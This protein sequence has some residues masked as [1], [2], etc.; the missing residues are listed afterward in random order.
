MSKKYEKRAI[1]SFDGECPMQCRHCFTHD[2]E[3]PLEPD[4][5]LRTPEQIA[6][7]LKDQQFDVIYLSRSYENFLDQKKA[8]HLCRILFD[9]YQKDLL[10]ITRSA[11]EEET[12]KKLG[13]LNRD[14]KQN[15]HRLFLACSFCGDDSYRISEDAVR[16]P[17]PKERMKN[18][19]LAHQYGICTILLLRP[20]FPNVIIPVQ[21]CIDLIDKARGIIDGVISSGLIITENILKRL[22]IERN[23]IPLMEDGDSEYL[24]NIA[25][26]KV[27]YVDVEQEL[28]LIEDHCQELGLPFF[29]HSMPA[30]NALAE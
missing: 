3:R 24:E 16:C 2:L 5:G 13:C 6:D 9:R 19:E 25:K 20:L 7:D 23:R 27:C 18:L 22:Q 28:A 8:L 30:L 11:L 26:D 12:V 21:E 14:M 15:G 17:N 1:V 4:G 10:I 29:R